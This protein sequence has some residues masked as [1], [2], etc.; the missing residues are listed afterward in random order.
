M[1][2]IQSCSNNTEQSAS[3]VAYGTSDGTPTGGPFSRAVLAGYGQTPYGIRDYGSWSHCYGEDGFGLIASYGETPTSPAT[4]A[5]LAGLSWAGYLVGNV[6]ISGN[7]GIGTTS[8]GL[9]LAVASSDNAVVGIFSE[10]D[11]LANLE[12]GSNGERERWSISS[13]SSSE[14][15]GYDFLIARN[16]GGWSNS[17]IIDWE[18]GNIG[19]G[20]NNPGNYRL[21]V[22]NYLTGAAAVRGVEQLGTYIY[23]EGQ[24]GVYSPTG[25]PTSPMNVGV[26]GIKGNAGLSGVAIYAYNSHGLGEDYSIYSACT[27]TGGAAHY[28][29]YSAASGATNNWAGYFNSTSSGATANYGVYA[30]ADSGAQN[31][32]IYGYSPSIDNYAVVGLQAGYDIGDVDVWSRPGVLGMGRNGVIGYTETPGGYAVFGLAASPA[33]LAGFFSGSVGIKSTSGGYDLRLAYDSAAKP[34]TNTWTIV[35]D[36]RLKTD[37]RPFTDGLDVLMQINPIRYRYNGLAET[38]TDK[39]NIGIIAQEIQKVC[40][41]TVGTFKQKLTPN[42]T[43]ETEL[44]DFNSHALTFVTINAVKEL[45]KK[46]EEQQK[47]I[48]ILRAEIAKLQ[49]QLNSK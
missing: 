34:S 17:M 46:I 26:L 9:E 33:A 4:S 39:E 11:G 24:L 36:I 40:P 14:F 10:G 19:M 49:K 30:T 45:N 28:G 8:P 6:Y 41:Y 31:I 21:C 18:T 22:S 42:D 1:G 13:R 38:P 25:L 3:I 27:G 20:T 29:I 32:A 37:I 48:E 12:F 16:N 44:L 23:A 7:V 35:S 47:E 5:Y 2:T 15:G 43:T